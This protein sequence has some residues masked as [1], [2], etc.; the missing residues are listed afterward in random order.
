MN[1]KAE[2]PTLSGQRLKTRKRGKCN[3]VTAFISL[4]QCSVVLK[5]TVAMCLKG[6]NYMLVSNHTKFFFDISL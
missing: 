1:Q 4:Q 5:M 3:L 2:K 6:L